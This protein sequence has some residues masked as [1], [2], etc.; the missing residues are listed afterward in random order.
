VIGR[1]LVVSVGA[2]QLVC[3]GIAYYFIGVFAGPIGDDLG[4]SPAIVFA[5]FSG[6]LLVMGLASPTIGRLIDHHGGRPV[7][8]AGSVLLAIGF[9][10]LSLTGNLATYAAAWL[11]IGLAM[12]MTLYDAAFAALSRIAGPEARSAISR[13]TLLGGL[14]ST[15]FW[16]AGFWLIH[17][18]GWRHALLVYAGLALA[19]VPVHWAIPDRRAAP[20]AEPAERESPAVSG[21][22]SEAALLYLF[23]MTVSAMVN[24]AV[25]AQ[26]IPLLAALG[27]APAAA[28]G[29]A[30]LRGIG[31][32]SAR[33]GE[34]MFGRR[35]SPFALTL[36]ATGAIPLA[37]A[38]GLFAGAAPA[39]AIAFAL[40]YG[41]GFGL[42]TIARG[43]LPLV[44]F[45]TR[46]YGATAGRLLAP[47]F[48][49]SALS[50][51]ACALAIERLG[52]RA[53]L[54]I[55]LALMLLVAAAAARL[56]RRQGYAA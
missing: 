29:V 45:P 34:V 36:L 20:T 43:T 42:L 10:V 39:A 26:M 1:P 21:R 30:S 4:W 16:P 15:V 41:A 18:L 50:P 33:L 49:L 47:G 52:V 3:W 53:A 38:C 7:M 6:A 8:T 31:Q 13:V 40:A 11:F 56:R 17:A 55:A 28:V 54:L 24:A 37:L 5:G 46:A 22:W 35:L 25:S 2:A 9:V 44:L 12:R 19:T 32:S 14:A 48:M 23:I 51:L 27:V